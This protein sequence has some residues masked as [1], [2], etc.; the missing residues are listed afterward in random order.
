MKV[1]HINSNY[2]YTKLHK[3]LITYLDKVSENT[4]FSPMIENPKNIKV[5]DDS[6]IAPSCFNKF[7]RLM[8]YNK[9]RKIIKSMTDN[10]DVVKHNLVHAHTLFT[11][12]N[13]AYK[14]YKK[15]KIPYIVTVRNTDINAFFKKRIFLR[16]RGVKILKNASAVIFLSK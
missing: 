7:D 9:Q 5:K 14:I 1:L 11:D 16:S 3:E 15:H 2:F 13:V 8:F 10:I 12:G 6:V 4:V